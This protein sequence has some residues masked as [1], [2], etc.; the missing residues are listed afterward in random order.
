MAYPRDS[1][2]SNIPPQYFHKTKNDSKQ[3]AK[4]ACFLHLVVAVNETHV[5]GGKQEYQRALVSFQST[6]SCKFLQ[7]IPFLNESYKIDVNC[8]DPERKCPD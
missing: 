1:P 7:L 5:W 6:S 2:P 4:E 3:R 8:L